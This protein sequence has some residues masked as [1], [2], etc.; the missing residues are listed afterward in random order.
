MKGRGIWCGFESKK[1]LHIFHLLGYYWVGGDNMD[2]LY[3]RPGNEEKFS[4]TIIDRA[5]RSEYQDEVDSVSLEL[6]L[7]ADFVTLRDT[8]I[9]KSSTRVDG[10]GNVYFYGTIYQ[11]K[12]I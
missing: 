11:L 2:N 12:Q 3:L 4:V 9:K 8:T 5:S 10:V 6:M 7:R 1:L